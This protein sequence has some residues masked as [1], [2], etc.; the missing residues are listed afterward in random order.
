M[1]AYWRHVNGRTL[2]SRKGR[3]FKDNVRAIVMQK[4]LCK[5]I[6]RPV[7]VIMRLCPPDKRKRDIDNYV[8]AVLDALTSAKVWLDDSLVDK[9]YLE[10]GAKYRGGC[11]CLS[12]H[13][14]DEITT[15]ASGPAVIHLPVPLF[16]N[17]PE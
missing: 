10:R 16:V 3:I 11:V 17:M 7:A 15:A 4:N 1:N 9:L 2:L 5:K 14:V 13:G 8:K 6:N 12:V